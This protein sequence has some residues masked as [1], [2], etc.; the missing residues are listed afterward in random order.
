MNVIS[1]H[2]SAVDTVECAG[3]IDSVGVKARGSA[4]DDVLPLDVV[5][6]TPVLDNRSVDVV[7]VH[8]VVP[9]VHP[10]ITM[11]PE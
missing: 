4:D 7:V 8:V 3:A 9:D 11:M 10:G 1:L 5:D 2:D 6:N